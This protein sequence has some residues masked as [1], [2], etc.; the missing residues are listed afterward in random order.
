MQIKASVDNLMNN[1]YD[2]VKNFPMPGGSYKIS[3]QLNNL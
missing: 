3:L 2:V 1:Q